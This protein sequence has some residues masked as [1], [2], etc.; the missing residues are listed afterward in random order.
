MD[1]LNVGSA[2]TIVYGLHFLES[3]NVNV[4]YVLSGLAFFMVKQ[5]KW[6]D[7]V[8]MQNIQV[9]IDKADLDLYSVN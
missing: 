8:S 5:L 1:D 7:P 9:D 4:R 2:Y 6:Y 3:S